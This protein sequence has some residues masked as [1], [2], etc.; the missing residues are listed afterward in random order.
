M[1]MHG[2]DRTWHGMASRHASRPGEN[3]YHSAAGRGKGTRSL[4][5]RASGMHG[6]AATQLSGQAGPCRNMRLSSVWTGAEGAPTLH[7]DPAS[8]SL[9]PRANQLY[10]SR[11]S[12]HQLSSHLERKKLWPLLL[13]GSTLHHEA[14][15]A[16]KQ[17]AG[18]IAAALLELPIGTWQRRMRAMSDGCEPAIARMRMEACLRTAIWH[19]L[20]STPHR[21]RPSTRPPERCQDR[22]PHYVAKVIESPSFVGGKNST[23]N[24]MLHTED[25]LRQTHRCPQAHSNGTTNA[26]SSTLLMRQKQPDQRQLGGRTASC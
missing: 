8:K 18:N 11:D 4:A 7:P 20:C 19:H 15:H 17:G 23:Q 25:D 1:C 14:P 12:P 6:R 5:D 21:R 24:S 13:N 16:C 10:R 9:S 2:Q 22:W 3:Q 26:A